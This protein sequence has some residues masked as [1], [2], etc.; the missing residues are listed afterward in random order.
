MQKVDERVDL[1][2]KVLNVEIKR[3]DL[4]RVYKEK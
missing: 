3:P 2:K 4:I 1:S